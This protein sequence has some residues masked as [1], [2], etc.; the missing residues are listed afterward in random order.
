MKINII[1]TALV[2]FI[3]NSTLRFFVPVL[4]PFIIS[5]LNINVYLG[6]LLVTAYWIGYTFMQIPSGIIADRIGISLSARLSFFAM[7]LLFT[8]FYFFRSYLCYFLI[9]VFIGAASAMVYVSD[10]AIVQAASELKKR[11][12]S[13]GIYQTGFFIGASLGEYL[14]LRTF[15]ISFDFSFYFIMIL[16][17]IALI[18]NILFMNYKDFKRPPGRID[19]NIVYVALIRFS[20][21]FSYIGFAA[22]FTTFI[23]YTGIVNYK[24]AYIYAWIPASGGLI[25]SPI[26]GIISSRLGINKSILSIIPVIIMD[27][28]IMFLNYL[29]KYIFLLSFF[30]GIMYGIYAGPSMGMASDFSG[31]DKNIASS[32]GIIN[33]SSQVGG[34]ISPIIIGFL[35]SIYHSFYIPFI[36]ISL[37]SMIVLTIPILKLR[38]HTRYL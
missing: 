25:T 30:T 16:L 26:G 36:F 1:G 19:R 21:G 29:K 20:A 5:N 15:D 24:N 31:G 22:I 14:V 34:T 12:E 38:I 23:V 7:V 32:S 17:I 6:S 8:G 9:Q 11:A 33:F 28:I 10:T 13:V 37:T 35:Y 4:L 2:S 27:F 3:M 18:L